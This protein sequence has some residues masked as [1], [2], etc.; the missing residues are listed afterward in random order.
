MGSVFTYGTC[1]CRRW[2]KREE[3]EWER[4]ERLMERFVRLREGVER[5]SEEQMER[6]VRKERD[7]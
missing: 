6:G 2:I 7:D 3:V 4:F 1:D 5:L